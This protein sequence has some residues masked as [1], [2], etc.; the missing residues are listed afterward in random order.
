MKIDS[1]NILSE[2]SVSGSAEISGSLNVLGSV[3]A[4]NFPGLLSSS[5]QIS[6]SGLTDIPAGIVSSST[7]VSY[8]GLTNIPAGIVSSSAQVQLGSITGTT[9]ASSNFTF[10][11]DLTVQGKITAQEFYTELISSSI[12]YESGSTKFGDT[13]DDTHEFTGSISVTGSLSVN[14]YTLP[15]T[16]GIY[17]NSVVITNAAGVLEF[18]ISK[19]IYEEVKNVSGGPLVKGTPVYVVSTT[20]NTNNVAP[21]DA[22]DPAKM[23]AS[24]ILDQALNN[25][26]EGLGI[27]LGFIN[28]INTSGLTAGQIVY[29]APGGG[30]TQTRPTGS[31]LVQSLGIPVRIDPTNGSGVIFNPGVALDLPNIEPGY[32]WVGDTN[33]VPTSASVASLRT[34]SYTGSFIGDGSGLINLVSA[35][36]AVNADTASLAN[37][38]TTA[39]TANTA[40]YVDW[41]NIDNVPAGIVSSS[42]QIASDISGSFTSVSQSIA[43]DIAGLVSDSG[44]FSIRITDLENFSAS[45]DSDFVSETEFALAT[46]SFLTTASISDDTI[47]LTKGDGTTFNLIV[48]NVEN[49]T[50]SS[51]I[52]WTDIDNVPAG[53]VSGSVQIQL[54][55]ISGTTF[56]ASNFTFPQDLIVQG[57]LTAQEFNTELISSSIIYESGSTKFG[58]TLDDVH[59]FTGSLEVFGGITGSLLAT[60]G[61]LSSSTQIASEISGAFTDVSQS[62]A[63]DIAGLIQDSGSFSIRISDLENFSSSLDSTFA[64]D[65]NL[66]SVSS[67]LAST[68]T[69]LD[70][71]LGTLEGKTLISSSLQI[72]SD[73]SGAFTNTSSSFAS[74]VDGLDSRLDSLESK[75]LVS[76]SSQI[77]LIDTTGDL[78]GS[79]IISIVASSSFA[80]NSSLLDGS[81]KSTFATTGSNTFTGTQTFNNIIVNGTGSFGYI[82]SVTGSAKVIGDA[83]ILLNENTPASNFAGIK[84]VDSGSIFTTASFVYDGLNNNW[85]FQHEGSEDSGSSLAIFG[86]LSQGGLGTEVGL[87]QNKVPKAVTNHGY[88]IGDSNITDTG[89][90]ITLGSN[91]IVQGTLSSTNTTLVSSSAQISYTGITNVPA[92]IVSGSAQVAINST[93]GTLDVNKGGTGQTTYTNGQLLIGNTT[94][95]TLTKATLTGTTNQ[96]TVTNGGGSITLSTPQDLHTSANFRIGSLGVGTNASGTTGEIRATNEITAYY[97]DDRLK[98][99]VD[100]IGN[101]LQKVNQLNGYYFVENDLAKSLGYTNDKVQVGVSAQEVQ[102]VLPEVVTTAPI[103]DQYL[104]VKYDKLVPLLIEAI[105]EQ[106]VVIKQLISDIDSLKNKLNDR[107]N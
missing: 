31:A 24:F 33:S 83:F 91:T 107:G 76:G 9:F 87:T 85:V 42:A 101:A 78:S 68:T 95:N 18:D 8:T 77:T 56:S 57:K 90:L 73:I 13:F 82:Q 20:G 71:R 65:S 81:D 6:Y 4:I 55:Q 41:T 92:G 75:T 98:N 66:T 102:A 79:R 17:P 103:D 21:A 105:K 64:T 16:D 61:I 99:K 47:T 36:H 62:I 106:D 45:L 84:V 15:V 19:T 54:D 44:S 40:S 22:S 86:P 37:F 3:T 63:S 100:K 35:S 48:N 2:L 27:I 25:D 80:I 1:P 96:L 60:N 12:I 74:S 7:Q 104:T 70:T 50:S 72:Q 38:A 93:T 14:D 29:V 89:T 51:Y 53:I 67:S 94:G 59:S 32:F 23:P 28:N 69:G 30:Y 49:A 5:A 11:Q 58:D 34:G 52:Q 26:E 88:H 10:P 39:G 43:A 46:G 97:S